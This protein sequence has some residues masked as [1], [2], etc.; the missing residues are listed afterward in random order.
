MK[1]TVSDKLSAAV[2]RALPLLLVSA[3]PMGF[4]TG[5][6]LDVLQKHMRHLK[7]TE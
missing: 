2:R 5:A 7:L 1:R 3:I 6:I 4:V